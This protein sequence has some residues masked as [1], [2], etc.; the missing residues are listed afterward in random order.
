MKASHEDE[1][2]RLELNKNTEEEKKLEDAKRHKELLEALT[3]KK[4]V[5]TATPVKEKGG[6]L[7]DSIKGMIS[8]AIKGV[9]E[10]VDKFIESFDFMKVLSKLFGGLQVFKMLLT[11]LGL[12]ILGSLIAVGSL[13]GLA[14]LMR[15]Y[16]QTIN[17]TNVY[18]PEQAVTILE[19][20]SYRDIQKQGGHEKFED[21]IVNG[22]KKAEE[23]LKRGD[24][25]EIA[26]AGGV[27][28]LNKVKSQ[29]GLAVPKRKLNEITVPP[30]PDTSTGQNKAKAQQWD[31][32][33]GKDF[34]PD[35]T[36][37]GPD[38]SVN[39]AEMTKLQRQATSSSG[40]PVSN[41]DN[42][43]AKLNTSQSENI[44]N[45]MASGPLVKATT[46][47][48][49]ETNV[50]KSTKGTPVKKPLPSVRNH[51]ESFS[52]MIFDSTRVV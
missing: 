52:R 49:N 36:P 3:G 48:I 6:G 17:N 10:W 31:M 33:F 27:D 2:K 47:H 20:G 7:F 37:K 42:L 41:T 28:F 50:T 21:I 24:P 38:D 18:T 30:R 13:I 14:E 26:N 5:S 35:G 43:G 11:F 22:P 19:N 16:I 44:S 4:V 1:I 34:M 12:P 29:T 9:K 25:I 39:T 46:K 32:K 51:E 40:V 15:K 8:D 45:R 23:I